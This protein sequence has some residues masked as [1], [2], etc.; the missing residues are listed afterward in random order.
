MYIAKMKI[1]LYNNKI[2]LLFNF[3]FPSLIITYI[4]YFYN[5]YT[6]MLRQNIVMNLYVYSIILKK[7]INT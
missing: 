6:S 4:I 7:I 2:V 1:S 5:Q 3:F